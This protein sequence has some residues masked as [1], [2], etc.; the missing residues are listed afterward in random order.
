M[1]L[2]KRNIG[3]VIGIV[4]G[5]GLI[6]LP[7][8]AQQMQHHG[9]GGSVSLLMRAAQLTPDQKTQ[10]RSIIQANRSTFR[11]IFSQLS[12]LRQ[13]VNSQLFSTGTVD[14]TLL[15]QINSLQGQLEQARLNVFQ[16]VWQLLNSAQQSQV[17]SVYSQVQAS[18]A[19]RRS[20]W[21]SLEQTPTR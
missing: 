16:Q 19:Q 21:Q 7:V 5:V 17:A 4:L 14:P 3:L 20:L 12:P 1:V 13:K 6:A 10:A 15:S 8:H 11:D 18:N 9:R 2:D